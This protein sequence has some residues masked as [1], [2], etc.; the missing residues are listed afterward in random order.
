MP[1][2]RVAI[3]LLGALNASLLRVGR[4]AGWLMLLAM[5]VVTLVEVFYR[6]TLSNSQPWT[7]EMSV[8]LMLWMTAL[9]APTAYRRAGFVAID[10]V[11]DLLAPRLRALLMLVILALS[12]AVLVVM[13]ERAWTRFANPFQSTSP[14]LNRVLQDS[15]LNAVLGT[16]IEVKLSWIYLSMVVGLALL[17]AVNVELVMRQVARLLGTE[18]AE[19]PPE[20]EPVVAE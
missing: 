2:L 8:A 14:A 20:A 15:G 3:R 1:A 19:A 6:Y 13:L 9:V 12:T 7:I 18:E 10:L 4:V 16:A 5:V 11:P 17:L